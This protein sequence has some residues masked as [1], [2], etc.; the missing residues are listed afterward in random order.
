MKRPIS[1]A[2]LILV[3]V[4]L[5]VSL[6]LVQPASADQDMVSKGGYHLEPV[7][8][9]LTGESSAPGFHL[10]VPGSPLLHGNGCCCTHL[11][12]VRKP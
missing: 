3:G 11:P 9:Q 1:I 4:S 12:C 10:R 8:W 7:R 5:L 2:L 6:A